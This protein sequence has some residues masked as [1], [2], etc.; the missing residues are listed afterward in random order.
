MTKSMSI[1]LLLSLIAFPLL[2]YSQSNCDGPVTGP[3]SLPIKNI[4][5]T[6]PVVRRGVALAVGTPPQNLAFG[7]HGYASNTLLIGIDG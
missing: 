6:E 2:C 3:L 4:S 5:L 1:P 7:I